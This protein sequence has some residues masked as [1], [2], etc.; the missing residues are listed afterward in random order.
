MTAED[1]A[2]EGKGKALGY[3]N[4]HDFISFSG[5]DL[6]TTKAIDASCA[7]AGQGGFIEIYAGSPTGKLVAKSEVKPTGN[8]QKW[9]IT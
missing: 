2:D 6:S 3:I 8:W 1:C 4:H 5:L 9:A 7:S